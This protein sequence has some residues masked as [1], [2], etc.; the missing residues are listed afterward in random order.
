MHGQG[1]RRQEAGVRLDPARRHRHP[2]RHAERRAGRAR[3]PHRPVPRPED[4]DRGRVLL[5]DARR[6]WRSATS[7][8]VDPMLATGNSAVAA[9]ERLK[10]L[11]PEVDQVRLPA[12]LPRRRAR[13][14]RTRTPTCRSTPPPSTAQLNEPRLHP[15]RAS[16]TRATASSARSKLAPR[17]RHFVSL[18]TPC[19]GQ[20]LR[21]A[22][23]VPRRFANGRNCEFL[24]EEKHCDSTPSADHSFGRHRR[25]ARGGGARPRACAGQAQGGGGLHRALRAAMGEPHPQGAEGGRGA[26]RDRIQGDARTSP[27]PTTSA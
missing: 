3:R 15:A 25:R 8:V 4:A 18:A 20:H 23:P 22:K 16:A 9:V 2:R 13:R 12:D 10:E 24:T 26:R 21:P 5:Q 7:I 17:L 14:C 11:Q 6:T 19:R 1:H 27:T